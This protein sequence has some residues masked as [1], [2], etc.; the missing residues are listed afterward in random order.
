[1]KGMEYDIVIV[2]AFL[3]LAIMI[4]LFFAGFIKVDL[5][6]FSPL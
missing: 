2:I 3:I 4:L 1:M 6:K 5:T